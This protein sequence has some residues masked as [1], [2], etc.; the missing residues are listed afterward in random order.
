MLF[1]LGDK[2]STNGALGRLHRG[3]YIGNDDCGMPLVAHNSRKHGYVLIQTA[4]E[5]SDGAPITVVSHAA[6]RTET[7]VVE[8]ALSL[9]GTRYNISTWNCEHFANFAQTGNAYSEQLSSFKFDLRVL[10]VS[11]LGLAFLSSGTTN[12]R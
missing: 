12:G 6:P 3:I 11:F 5:F 1:R 9:L 2:L 4:Y 10:A 8:R 7:V